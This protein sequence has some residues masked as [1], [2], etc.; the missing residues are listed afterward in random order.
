MVRLHCAPTEKFCAQILLLPVLFVCATEVEE[1]G[2]SGETHN[3]KSQGTV[4]T[5]ARNVKRWRDGSMVL[6]WLCGTSPF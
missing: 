4:G 2:T 6:R 5:V 1:V 3:R